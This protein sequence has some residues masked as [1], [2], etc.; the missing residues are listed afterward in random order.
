[1]THDIEEAILLATRIYVLS[2]HPGRVIE[3]ISVPFGANRGPGVR[4]DQ[5]FLDLR[6]EIQE[7]LTTQ[8]ER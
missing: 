4:R 6:D 8:V 2:S 3:D 5:R 1:M 7:V